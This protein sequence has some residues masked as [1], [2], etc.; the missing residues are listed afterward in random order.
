MRPG[1][2]RQ[3]GL[4]VGRVVGGLLDGAGEAQ[5]ALHAHVGQEEGQDRGDGRDRR[6]RS[7]QPVAG[8][9]PAAA[10]QREE[11][12]A[13]RG[14]QPGEDA[15][16]AAGQRL[17]REG[18]AEERRRVRRTAR[19][20][21]GASPASRPAGRRTASAGCAPS[22]RTGTD[23]R[24]SRSPRRSTRRCPASGSGPA[25]RRR[26]TPARCRG[27]ST[28]CASRRDCR[29]AGR[30][31]GPAR[32]RRCCSPS[33]PACRDAGRRCSRR[34]GRPDWWRGHA[35]PRPR[36]RCSSGRRRCRSGRRCRG[37]A[38]WGR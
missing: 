3:P 16:V 14:Q 28:G 17:Y 34:T 1:A 27:A 13:E 26:R 7:A 20:R 24:R 37:A 22:A 38:R 9:A 29:S 18:Q 10:R 23:R 25:R 30:R 11:R 19:R 4:E 2:R 12:Q 36:T 32:R 31:A 8:R 6:D 35:T 33:R 15:V 21:G 5:L